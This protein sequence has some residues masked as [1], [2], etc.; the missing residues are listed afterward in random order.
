MLAALVSLPQPRIAIGE[1]CLG[2]PSSRVE[3]VTPRHGI[4]WLFVD[5]QLLKWL[6]RLG[7][8]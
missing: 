8:V 7:R 2:F 6:Q 3:R 1:K 4:E 5:E